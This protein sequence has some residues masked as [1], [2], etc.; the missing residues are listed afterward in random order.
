MPR[1]AHEAVCPIP[2]IRK[3]P[4][5]LR[6]SDGKWYASK[7]IPAK[8]LVDAYIVDLRMFMVV[9]TLKT[10]VIFTSGSNVPKS[11]KPFK[12]V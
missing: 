11:H 5:Y 12:S 3:D 2:R 7:H 9:D 6:S 10:A 8:Q 1:L 4:T